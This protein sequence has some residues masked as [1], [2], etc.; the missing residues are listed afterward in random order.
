M[1]VFFINQGRGP[2]GADKIAGFANVMW[3]NRRDLERG[4]RMKRVG[5]YSPSSATKIN[6]QKWSFF[7]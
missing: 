2:P 3:Q 5:I 4:P 1:V 7:L 6:D